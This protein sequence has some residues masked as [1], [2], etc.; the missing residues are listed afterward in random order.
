[1]YEV[2]DKIWLAGR[3]DP[4][5]LD[6]DLGFFDEDVGRVEPATNPFVPEL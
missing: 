5:F 1:M 6:Y 2:E 4:S 3:P